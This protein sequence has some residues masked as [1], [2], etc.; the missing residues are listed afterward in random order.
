MTRY[1]FSA[2]M[3]DGQVGKS[4]AEIIAKRTAEWNKERTAKGKDGY[5]FVCW[6]PEEMD[7]IKLSGD[8]Q[9]YIKGHHGAGAAFISDFDS[10]NQQQVQGGQ[11]V[12]V[13]AT[14]LDP[15]KLTSRLHHC[16]HRSTSFKGTIK[17]FNCSSGV[18]G[19]ASFAKLA[20]D[21]MRSFWPKAAY[22][23][24]AAPLAQG[25]GDYT[26]PANSEL[27]S[28]QWLLNGTPA[29]VER[30]KLGSTGQRASSLHV[31]L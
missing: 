26:V 2:W 31:P 30:R 25:Y 14:T 18:N 10:W 17:F 9:I 4:V 13:A 15:K 21:R 11:A 20:A 16:F 8:D 23:G 19:G 5:T 12:V 24:Y 3:P 22:I 27:Q 28:L 29:P 6:Q 1:V 7:K